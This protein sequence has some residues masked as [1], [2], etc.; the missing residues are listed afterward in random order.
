MNKSGQSWVLWARALGGEEG[1]R[2]P[3][4]RPAGAAHAAR[5]TPVAGGDGRGPRRTGGGGRRRAAALAA[6]A[7]A[8]QAD[9]HGGGRPVRVPRGIRRWPARPTAGARGRKR[10]AVEGGGRGAQARWANAAAAPCW[11]GAVPAL[12]GIG[13]GTRA[14]F[15]AA[16]RRLQPTK[17]AAHEAHARMSP[18]ISGWWTMPSSSRI[19]GR[20]RAAI[21]PRRSCGLPIWCGARP[22]GG[23]ASA[24][25]V[26]P[27]RLFPGKKEK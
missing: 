12:V 27:I 9:P 18:P 1:C 14:F 13:R 11:V 20:R 7:A 10:Q 21:R 3:R 19:G 4:R 2:R 25:V 6:S 26:W 15:W 23:S 16:R 24:V 8:L 22:S 17:P 5:E